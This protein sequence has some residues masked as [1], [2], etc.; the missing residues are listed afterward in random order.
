MSFSNE[1]FDEEKGGRDDEALAEFAEW[2]KTNEKQADLLDI[3]RVDFYNL[4][5]NQASA[6]SYEASPKTIDKLRMATDTN[7]FLWKPG[8]SNKTRNKAVAAWWARIKKEMDPLR[9]LAPWTD[10][11]SMAVVMEDFLARLT[12]AME[13]ERIPGLF[14]ASIMG[15]RM[16]SQLEAI[17]NWWRK[18]IGCPDFPR[19]RKR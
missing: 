10:L 13:E 14:E 19:R 16:K 1:Y 3:S 17:E 12:E 9:K 11:V 7:Y 4:L 8:G 15:S 6:D 2:C 5:L 18:T